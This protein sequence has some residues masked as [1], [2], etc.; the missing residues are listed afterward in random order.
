M[1]TQMVHNVA[2]FWGGRILATWQPKKI[3]AGESN[4]GISEFKKT[5]RHILTKKT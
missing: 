5:I 2:F 3:K 4:K 1:E